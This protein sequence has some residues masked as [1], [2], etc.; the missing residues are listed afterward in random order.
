[1]VVL[2]GFRSGQPD[3]RAFDPPGVSHELMGV[4]EP[5]RDPQVRLSKQRD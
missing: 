1:M 2:D 4:D 3:G 5:D